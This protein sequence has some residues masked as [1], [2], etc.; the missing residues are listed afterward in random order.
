MIS[1]DLRDKGTLVVKPQGAI[2][3]G[4]RGGSN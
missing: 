3:V 1:F 4:A 2:E